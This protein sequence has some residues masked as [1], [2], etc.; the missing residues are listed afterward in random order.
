MCRCETEHFLVNLLQTE[1]KDL[2]KI[3]VGR[4]F[5]AVK[6]PECVALHQQSTSIS[7]HTHRETPLPLPHVETLTNTHSQT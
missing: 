1:K 2:K 4:E 5:L 7:R 3:N 6:F